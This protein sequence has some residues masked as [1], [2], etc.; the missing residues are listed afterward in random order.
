MTTPVKKSRKSK[1]QPE[2]RP[3]SKTTKAYTFRMVSLNERPVINGFRYVC[4][5]TWFR[6]RKYAATLFGVDAT[7][8]VLE[9]VDPRTA[10]PELTLMVPD[11]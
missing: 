9:L 10:P 5:V 4:G 7:A 8:L 11:A 3:V 1:K 2:V 6:C